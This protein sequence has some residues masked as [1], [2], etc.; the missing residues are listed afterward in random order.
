MIPV[1]IKLNIALIAAIANNNVIGN[2][3]LIPWEIPQ[4]MRY[5]RK[6]TL[7]QAVIMGRKT[8]ESI[9]EQYRPLSKR[10]N[11]IITRQQNYEQ[12][13]AYVAHSLDEALNVATLLT[14]Q[15]DTPKERIY[16]AGGSEIYNIAM[17]L[18]DRLEIT[19]VHADF[20]GDTFFPAIDTQMWDEVF[21]E[22]HE[23]YSFLRYERK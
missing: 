2:E 6:R 23:G 7:R 19:R 17:P 1:N 20:K 5:F 12:E 10:D 3:G 14:V 4:D 15:K 21:K 13:G 22:D 18:A 9:P 8:Y 16:I 11:I